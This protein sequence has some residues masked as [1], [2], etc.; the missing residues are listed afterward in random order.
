[1]E[2]RKA[3]MQ[4]GELEALVVPDIQDNLASFADFVDRGSTI[5]FTADCG[6]ITIFL[7]IHKLFCSKILVHGGIL[8]D[9][10]GYNHKHDSHPAFAASIS[11]TK[12][13]RYIALLLPSIP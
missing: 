13:G 7:M 12:L 5:I 2:E 8:A 1:M 3:L 9:I 11:N 6:A 4:L 10:V